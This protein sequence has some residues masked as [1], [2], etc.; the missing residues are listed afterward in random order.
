MRINW[1]CFLVIFAALSIFTASEVKAQTTNLTASVGKYYFSLSGYVSPFAS[2]VMSSSSIFMGSVVADK[3]GN[4]SLERI[5]INEGFTDFCLEAVDLKRVGDSFTCLKIPPATGDTQKKDIFLPPTV[6]LSA[7]K[8]NPG[9]SIFASG[10]SMPNAKVL[11]NISEGIIL[12]ANAD[13]TGFYKLEIKDLP[14]GKYSLFATARYERKDSEKPT[15]KLEIESLSMFDLIK[16]NF[17]KIILIILIVIAIIILLI[18]LLSKKAREKIKNM[19]KKKPFLKKKERKHLHHDWL[20][21]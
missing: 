10:Y 7:R 15:K 17:P 13:D 2:V 4:F 20:L 9:S 18:I 14:A 3:E 5:L 1:V 12:Q 11:L 21:G 16:Q 19:I 8:I 6:G